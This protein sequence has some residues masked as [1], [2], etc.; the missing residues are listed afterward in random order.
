MKT[1]DTQSALMAALF[2]ARKLYPKIAKTKNGQAG[3]RQFKY[4]P[5]EDILAAVEPVNEAHGLLVTQP[6]EGHN[7]ITRLDHIPSGEW[8]E[9][10]MP[11]NVEHANM[12]SYGIELTYRKRYAIQ[13][14]LGIIT[15]ED[16]DGIDGGKKRKGVDHTDPKNPNGTSK[17][18][19]RIGAAQAVLAASEAL[20]KNQVATLD[21]LATDVTSEFESYGA[22]AAWERIDEQGLD[23]IEKIYLSTKLAS[24]VR[25]Q[26]TAYSRSLHQKEPA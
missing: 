23:D 25:N 11:V 2:E 26:I 4:A 14:I 1:S 8:R 18:P 21:R 17:G 9:A 3:N 15:E 10:S 13:G 24:G 20:S 7:I 22:Q 6:V 5:M 12:Q 19:G 16:T